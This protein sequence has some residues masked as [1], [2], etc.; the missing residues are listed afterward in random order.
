MFD[1]P[2]ALLSQYLKLLEKCGVP[3]AS[4]AECIKWSRYFWNDTLPSSTVS[5]QS[6]S[7]RIFLRVQELRDMT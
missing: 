6:A 4:F 1:F 5:H 2:K 3:A 7:P